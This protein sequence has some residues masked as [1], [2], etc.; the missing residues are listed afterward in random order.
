MP[1]PLPTLL[2]EGPNE[3]LIVTV[4]KSSVVAGS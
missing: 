1:N 4:A 3:S 2:P